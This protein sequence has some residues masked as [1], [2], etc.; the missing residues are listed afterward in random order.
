MITRPLVVGSLL[1]LSVSL[2]V[3]ASPFPQAHFPRN[4][5]RPTQ[6]THLPNIINLVTDTGSA[7]LSCGPIEEFYKPSVDHW[8]A[9]STDEWLDNWWNKHQDEFGTNGGFS[10]VFGQYAL[11]DPFFSCKDTGESGNCNGNVC[12]N[13]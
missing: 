2:L 12:A 8:E 6:P 9:S 13:L 3:A 5:S 11:G 10:T 7:E 4:I 1:P